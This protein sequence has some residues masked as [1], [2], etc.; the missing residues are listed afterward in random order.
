MLYDPKD[1]RV[2]SIIRQVD[3]IWTEAGPPPVSR[4]PQGTRAASF[5]AGDFLARQHPGDFLDALA[6]G[7]AATSDVVMP[8]GNRLRDTEMVAA[9]RRHLRAVGHDQHLR[10]R[11]AAPAAGPPHRRWPADAAIDLVKIG[12]S[13]SLPRARQ[14]FSARRKREARRPRRSCQR[15]RPARR[16]GGDGESH[17]IATFGARIGIGQARFKDRALHLRGASSAAIAASSRLAAAA[18]STASAPAAAS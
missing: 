13:A 8:P 2:L 5:A 6:V 10:P 7:R 12:T 9:K 4:D 11:P 17:G 14:T 1:G 3:E 16:V 18:R 15:P